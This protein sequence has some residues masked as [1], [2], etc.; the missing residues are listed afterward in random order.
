MVVWE[1]PPASSRQNAEYRV[2]HEAV[3][4]NPNQFARV[5]HVPES[6]VTKYERSKIRVKW[7]Q[8]MDRRC[9]RCRVKAV[10]SDGHYSI[11]VIH[12]EGT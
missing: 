6:E 5:V 4:K 2:V 10:T 1:D 9:G 11:Y 3:H 12:E 7:A 8:A